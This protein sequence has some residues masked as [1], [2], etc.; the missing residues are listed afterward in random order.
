MLV[1]ALAALLGLASWG[2]FGWGIFEG[3]STFIYAGIL[4]FVVSAI[5]YNVVDSDRTLARMKKRRRPWGEAL[6]TDEKGRLGSRLMFEPTC[7]K[8]NCGGPVV[9]LT[10]GRP[11][12]DPRP[13]FGKFDP[14]LPDY[15]VQGSAY[16]ARC[17]QQYT[18]TI[19]RGA[20]HLSAPESEN[21]LR[22]TFQ[23]L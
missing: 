7:L 17:K 22:Q 16:C 4:L 20:L 1:Q 9:E 21:R 15:Y 5:L 19:I 10:N 18:Y 8:P 23:P 14:N 2:L 11:P 12:A 13:F 3:P 6:S